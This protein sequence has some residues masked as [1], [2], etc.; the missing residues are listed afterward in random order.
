MLEAPPS[1][2]TPDKPTTPPQEREPDA[3][4]FRLYRPPK[5]TSEGSHLDLPESYFT[6]SAADLKA[7]QASL[8]A[9]THSLVDAPLQTQIMR[10]AE[11]K[12]KRARYPTTTIR[13]KFSDRTQLQKEF[14]SSD[15]IRSVYAFVR[16]S[17]REDV[18]PI[19]F[20][21]YQTPPKR[22]LKVSDPAVRDL[23]LYDLHLAPSSVLH[24]KFLD[25]SL[26]HINVPA[27]LDEAVLTHAEDLPMPPDVED[28]SSLGQQNSLKTGRVASSSTG[29]TSESPDKKIAKWLK[30]GPK[31]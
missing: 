16:G 31:K 22:E 6:P 13:V 24:L 5:S 8:S 27:P 1:T 28:S 7:A 19:K 30:L 3:P 14:P 2:S 25:E 26:N 11:D 23:S 4:A 20:I 29:R 21:L 15:K 17:L 9:R 18:K 12:V 10:D